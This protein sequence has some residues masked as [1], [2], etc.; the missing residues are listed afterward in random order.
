MLWLRPIFKGLH[1][2]W[3]N[4]VPKAPHDRLSAKGFKYRE[5]DFMFD[6]LDSRFWQLQQFH[7][8]SQYGR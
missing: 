3:K 8:Y 2:S 4:L 5:S 7:A 1:N 6:E